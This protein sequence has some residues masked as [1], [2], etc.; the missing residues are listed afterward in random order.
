M[1][2]TLMI[3]AVVL[4]GCVP[5]VDRCLIDPPPC[6]PVR[7]DCECA[8]SE[9]SPSWS[10]GVTP[11]P[12]PAPAP[13]DPKPP[14]KPEPKPKDDHGHGNDPGKFEHGKKEGH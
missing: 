11:A 14:T 2:P 5:H 12:A 9:G 3:A 10:M 4:A 7:M 8:P 13:V 6:D 1:K